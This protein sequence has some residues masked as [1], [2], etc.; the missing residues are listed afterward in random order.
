MPKTFVFSTYGARG[1]VFPYL[2]IA[3][4][5]QNRGHR[6]I[7]ATSES[8]RAEIESLGLEFRAVRPD[9]PRGENSQKMMHPVSGTEFLFRR[10]LL[11]TLRESIADLRAICQNADVLITH[12]TSLAGP[13]AAQLPENR[14]LKWVSS[15]VSPLALLE[16]DVALPACPRAADFPILN[17]AIL[18]VLRRQFGM[19]LKQTQEIRRSL[20][21]SRGDNA[22]WSDAHSS[23]LQLALWPEKFAPIAPNSRRKAVGFCFLDA[24][25]SLAP[26]IEDFLRAGQAPLIFVAASFAHSPQ[27]ESECESAAALLGQRAILL[28]ASQNSVSESVLRCEFASLDALLPRTLALIH[29]GGI[30]TLALGLRAATPMLLMPR[31]HDQFDNARRASKLGLA[32]VAKRGNLAAQI[33]ALLEDSALKNRLQNTRHEFE[34]GA[35]RAADILDA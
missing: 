19:N 23:G 7:V 22:L 12:T 18:G 27:W 3:R 33:G 35:S 30:G 11:P 15:A 17:R 9:S 4:E 25:K 6:A 1:D 16:S 31:A 32:H 8:Y 2:A 20:G 34:N 26:E 28:G 10:L 5:L 14:H 13:I 24:P 21:V 29:A